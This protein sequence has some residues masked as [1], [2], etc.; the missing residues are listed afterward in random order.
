MKH[1][2]QSGNA[3]VVIIIIL[4]IAVIGL[5]GFVFWQNFIM[6][7]TTPKTQ[8]T[9]GITTKSTATDTTPTTTTIL[10]FPAY[11]VEIPYDSSADT[12]TIAPS[13]SSLGGYIIYS[14]K[15]TVACDSTTDIGTIRQYDLGDGSIPTPSIDITVGQHIYAL[16]T[17][18]KTCPTDSGLPVQASANEAIGKAYANLKASE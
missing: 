13:D 16:F 4:V 1:K 9:T 2:T 12:Y 3:Q 5:V 14:K 11:G 10:D 15:T 18:S 7:N 8:V 17:P 6:K